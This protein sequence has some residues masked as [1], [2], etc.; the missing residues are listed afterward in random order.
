M[1]ALFLLALIFLVAGNETAAI[2]CL[3]PGTLYI[4][5]A[6]AHTIVTSLFTKKS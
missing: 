1:E 3:M 5:C 2:L 6:I 4:M